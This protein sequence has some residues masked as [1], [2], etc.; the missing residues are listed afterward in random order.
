LPSDLPMNEEHCF[1]DEGCGVVEATMRSGFE[2]DIRRAAQVSIDVVSKR[3][4]VE[5]SQS[6]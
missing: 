3:S 2:A 6:R 4:G 1:G 5:I